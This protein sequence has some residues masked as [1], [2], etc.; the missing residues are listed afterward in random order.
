VQH[1]KLAPSEL[2]RGDEF[3]ASLAL[4]NDQLVVG[5]RGNNAVPQATWDFE[6]GDLRG[7]ML[8]GTAF[9]NQPTLGAPDHACIDS[10]GLYRISCIDPAAKP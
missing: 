8:T 4:D 2:V 1:A 10:F 6:L 9:N 3:G 5:A 7:W